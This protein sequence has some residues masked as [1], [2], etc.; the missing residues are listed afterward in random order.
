MLQEIFQEY[1]YISENNETLLT[2]LT[3][4]TTY[5]TYFEKIEG[6][7]SSARKITNPAVKTKVNNR[8]FAFKN[9]LENRAKEVEITGYSKVP[10]VN[11]IF[12]IGEE[13]L[14]YPLSNEQVQSI[15]EYNVRNDYF[16]W[17]T[18]FRID[19]LTDVL[20]NQKYC[21]LLKLSKSSSSFQI[22]H[23]HCTFYKN[24][25]IESINFTKEDDLISFITG[26]AKQC[27]ESYVFLYYPHLKFASKTEQ[28]FHELDRV[29][30]FN[31]QTGIQEM[32]FE[33]V[34]SERRRCNDRL[35]KKCKEMN[36]EKKMD[37]FIFGKKKDFFEA[38][39][40][41]II[42]ELYIEESKWN[43]WKKELDS[44]LL[45]F[46]VIVIT[47]L[48]KGDFADSWIENYKG[49]MGIKYY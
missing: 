37:T 29:L 21:S 17:G 14:A 32:F 1:E 10:Y 48:E 3:Y 8:L 4:E 2:V 46:E 15:K 35:E 5:E 23:V 42:K 12:L 41:Y 24:K 33:K 13:I 38:I 39:E 40:C 18:S 19:F 25:L 43:K 47:S 11:S 6:E 44:S 20:F 7:L 27:K 30:P 9:W 28:L 34:I 49:M 22:E 31:K 45:N 36:D 16:V 26:L